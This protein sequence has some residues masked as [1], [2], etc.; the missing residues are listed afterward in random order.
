M[1]GWVIHSILSHYMRNRAVS[2][3]D[4]CEFPHHHRGFALIPT[5]DQR[6][7]DIHI[8]IF[9]HILSIIALL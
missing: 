9:M 8:Y 2:A 7:A 4:L 3:A 6:R 5:H 1:G